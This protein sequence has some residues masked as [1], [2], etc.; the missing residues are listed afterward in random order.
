MQIRKAMTAA[1]VL[2]LPS[3]MLRPV[4]S[5]FGHVI[6]PG[7]KIG[8]SAIWV[9]KLAL[10]PNAR[11]GHFNFINCRKIVMHKDAAIVSF[12]YI[13]GPLSLR[14]STEAFIGRR[15]QVVRARIPVSRGPGVLR[16]GELCQITSAHRF[17]CMCSVKIGSNT[18][19]AGA[20][21]QVWTHGYIHELTGRGRLRID[22]EVVIGNNVYIGSACIISMGVRIVD[23]VNVGSHSSVSKNLLKSGLYVSQALRYYPKTSK[24][25]EQDLVR[26]PEIEVE[27]VYRKRKTPSGPV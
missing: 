2:L 26:V 15:N 10:G 9:D 19:F 24:D 14:M 20:G 11:I 16:M 27:R 7:A 5:L 13:R 17:D 8:F 18:T 25:Y 3:G 22:G 21:S 6:S 4:L 1:A 12:N 23:G